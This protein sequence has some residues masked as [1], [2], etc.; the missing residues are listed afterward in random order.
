MNERDD[1]RTVWTITHLPD[2]G[3]V[4]VTLSVDTTAP[5]VV[6]RIEQAAAGAGVVLARRL[7]VEE[8]A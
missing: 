5:A 6:E 3:R 7:P 8:E 2:W 1:E 4:S